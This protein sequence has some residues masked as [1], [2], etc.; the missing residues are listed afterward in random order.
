M[1][2]PETAR[3]IL[4]LSAGVALVAAG[5]SLLSLSRSDFE[6]P[7]AQRFC[8]LGFCA[9][10]FSVERVFE[11]AQKATLGDPRGELN[12]FK[13]ALQLSPASA[14][15]WADIA[16]AEFNVRDLKQAE[17]AISQAL[18]AGPR[19]PVILMRSANLYFEIGETNLVTQQLKK[20]L[21]DPGLSDY[22]DTAFLTYSRLGLP[23]DQILQT[24]VPPRKS[25]VSG[26]LTFWT[27]INKGDEA[28]ETWKWASA[29]SL[30]DGPSMGA[31]FR[32]LLH[33]GQ[34]EEAQQLWQA[35]A[36]KRE[37]GYRNTNWIYNSG[38]DTEPLQS[39]FDWTIEGRQDVEAEIVQDVHYDGA[40]SFR[41]RFN[42]ETNTAYHQTYQSMV[43]PPGKYEV[44]LMMKTEQVTTDEGVRLHIFDPP[45]QSKVNVWLDTLTG[46]QDWT[47]ISKTFEVP[48]GVKLLQVELA[49]MSSE[50][51]DNK[52]GGTTWVDALRLANLR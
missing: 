45:S 6:T 7:Q 23:V 14:Y 31:F 42:G 44:S 16:E 26:L 25:V 28:V 43:L 46:T 15:R 12:D 10:Q 17:Y 36:Q 48:P 51:F 49:R 11:I 5:A 39:P 27:K 1:P 50:K 8:R 35:F 34:S 4:G 29:R 41:I 2:K 33:A 30:A 13:R 37:P 3:R 21:S 20:L 47:K 38:F 52:I 18:I 40:S 22:Y 32:Y 9:D 24:G 19:S